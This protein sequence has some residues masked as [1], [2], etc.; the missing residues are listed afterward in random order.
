MSDGTNIDRKIVYEVLNSMVSNA[1]MIVNYRF[2]CYL[3]ANTILVLAWVELYKIFSGLD[4]SPQLANWK[5]VTCILAFGLSGFGAWLSSAFGGLLRRT[6]VYERHY[7]GWAAQMEID[8]EYCPR[9]YLWTG[10][11]REFAEDINK[12]DISTSCDRQQNLLNILKSNS[13][14]EGNNRNEKILVRQKH[15][16]PSMIERNSE[17]KWEIKNNPLDTPIQKHSSTSNRPRGTAYN[18]HNVVTAVF[19]VFFM[20]AIL[21]SS[22]KLLNMFHWL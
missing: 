16:L 13:T 21:L 19:G 1:S 17:N 8:Q 4:T 22:Y 7:T 12:L 20:I 9:P 3:V 2:Y 18:I 15:V 6:K 5:I 10:L 14:D 11:I